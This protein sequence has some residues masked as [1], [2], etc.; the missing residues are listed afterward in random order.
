MKT[1]NE[2]LATARRWDKSVDFSSPMTAWTQEMF[3][4]L[5]KCDGDKQKATKMLKEVSNR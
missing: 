1:Y 4:A 2:Q 3:D 5:M